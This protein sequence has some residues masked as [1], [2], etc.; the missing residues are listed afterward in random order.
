MSK[1]G[2]DCYAV[3]GH[4]MIVCR[5]E[6][7]DPGEDI[8]LTHA[9]VESSETPRHGHAWVERYAPGW[10]WIVDDKSN[11]NDV[12][13][14]RDFYYELGRVEGAVYYTREEALLK[15]TSTGHYGPWHDDG[16][17]A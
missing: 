3:A 6:Q 11:G 2:G 5:P 7:F 1:R 14:P 8:R 15:M 9:T 16:V 12:T 10:G 13:L 4:A 17:E